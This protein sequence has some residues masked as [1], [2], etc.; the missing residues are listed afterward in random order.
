ML[1]HVGLW[2]LIYVISHVLKHVKTCYSSL[3]MCVIIYIIIFTQIHLWRQIFCQPLMYCS[4]A[5]HPSAVRLHVYSHS[6][7]PVSGFQFCCLWELFKHFAHQNTSVVDFHEPCCVSLGS[8]AALWLQICG[9]KVCLRFVFEHRMCV[10][11]C[12]L[13]M[14]YLMSPQCSK[15]VPCW[16]YGDHLFSPL[17]GKLNFTKTCD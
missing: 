4:I 9:S 13:C 16:C 11:V 1:P 12:G 2:A 14:Y 5:L 3:W 17:M 8:T 15:N 6:S 10:C 7:N